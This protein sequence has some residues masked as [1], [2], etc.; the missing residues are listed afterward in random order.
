VYTRVRAG[1][2]VWSDGETKKNKKKRK[3]KM[4]RGLKI[5]KSADRTSSAYRL[6][7]YRSLCGLKMKLRPY[8]PATVAAAAAAA[9]A[10]ARVGISGKTTISFWQREAIWFNR[11]D[12]LPARS[13]IGGTV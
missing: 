5:G 3:K 6:Y 7:R 4:K 12:R 13:S 8:L 2:D 11:L 9:A 1:V 10:A